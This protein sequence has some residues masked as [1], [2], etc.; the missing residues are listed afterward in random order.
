MKNYPDAEKF[1]EEYLKNNMSQMTNAKSKLFLL[2]NN[3]SK[4]DL[5]IN[6]VG[7][8]KKNSDNSITYQEPTDDEPGLIFVNDLI[9]KASNFDSEL[10]AAEKRQV[11][12]IQLASKLAAV[13]QIIHEIADMRQKGLDVDTSMPKLNQAVQNYNQVCIAYK[14]PEVNPLSAT[15]SYTENITFANSQRQALEDKGIISEKYSQTMDKLREFDKFT[16]MAID[17]AKV[18]YARVKN[19]GP[20]RNSIFTGADK[21]AHTELLGKIQAEIDSLIDFRNNIS[22]TMTLIN[23]DNIRDLDSLNANTNIVIER[24]SNMDAGKFI[25]GNRHS[26]TINNLTTEIQ[27]AATELQQAPEEQASLS[28]NQ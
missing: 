21:Q 6:G 18:E 1:L 7:G 12:I 13:E 8:Y 3:S 28:R 17:N 16:E 25:T 2:E 23:A 11:M 15:S 19:K 10:T 24:M 14:V 27:K 22:S 26:E 20:K 4:M 5:I 9:K